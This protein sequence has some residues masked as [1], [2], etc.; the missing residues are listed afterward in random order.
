MFYAASKIFFAPFLCD[1]HFYP[2]FILL[3]IPYFP[4]QCSPAVLSIVRSFLNLVF[5]TSELL[6]KHQGKRGDWR[7]HWDNQLKCN[8]EWIY[9][10]EWPG[11]TGGHQIPIN[12]LNDITGLFLFVCRSGGQGSQYW[13]NT[14]ASWG[15]VWP[16]GLLVSVRGLELRWDHQKSQG[17]RPHCMWVHHCWPAQQVKEKKDRMLY[18]CS[19][20]FLRL[21]WKHR[22]CT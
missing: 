9:R 17:I 12:N 6:S 11:R 15:A 7:V 22:T 5:F 1:I 19:L 20:Y 16:R 3:V 14:A 2:E 4:L 21:K 8:Q 10:L 13:N 18:K